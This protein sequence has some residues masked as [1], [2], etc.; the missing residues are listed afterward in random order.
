MFEKEAHKI[1]NSSESASVEMLSDLYYNLLK[2]MFGN[3]VVIPKHSKY[4]WMRIH[5][6]FHT[7]FYQYA[8]TFGMLMT[9]AL[10]KMYKEEGKSFV[11]K[12]EKILSYGGSESPEKILSEVGIDINSREFWQSGFDVIKEKIDELESLM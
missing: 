3:S 7:P 11:P 12:L 9:L 8:Y 2:K 1:I 10:Y 6:M 4:R 5:H